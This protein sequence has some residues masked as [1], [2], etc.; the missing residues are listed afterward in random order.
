LPDDHRAGVCGRV[1]CILD[2]SLVGIGIATFEDEREATD[3]R[4]HRERGDDDDL[5]PLS[6]TIDLAA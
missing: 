4:H 6:A 2:D 1:G 5:A 3:Q